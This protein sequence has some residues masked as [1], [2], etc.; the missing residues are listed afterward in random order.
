MI[1]PRISRS[2]TVRRR[3]A[4][5]GRGK[6]II[7]GDFVVHGG[8]MDDANSA[9]R[10]SPFYRPFVPRALAASASGRLGWRQ[11]EN[12]KVVGTSTHVGDRLPP[13]Y[14]AIGGTDLTDIEVR[15]ALEVLFVIVV[16]QE[17]SASTKWH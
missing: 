1:S 13:E 11:S 3:A 17:R 2:D 7:C 5:A 10:I 16:D 8:E 9:S 4:A 15:V 6:K 12:F 14:R